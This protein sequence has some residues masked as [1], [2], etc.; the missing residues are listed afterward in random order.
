MAK[1]QEFTEQEGELLIQSLNG[2]T[3]WLNEIGVL[4]ALEGNK[5]LVD[6]PFSTQ[7]WLMQVEGDTVSFNTEVRKKCSF[8]YYK[9]VVL[10]ESFHLMVQKIPNKGD[11]TRIK[12]NFGDQLMKL[13]D[14]EAD[15]YTA[16]YYKEKLNYTLVKFLGLYFDGRTV[17]ND[18]RIRPG[19]FE[20]YIGSLLSVAKLFIEYPKV[21][22]KDIEYDL[23]LPTIAPV[24][25]ESKLHV[26]VIRKKHIYLDEISA[27]HDDFVKLMSCYKDVNDF[28]K[29]AYITKLIN[30]IFKAFN[31]EIPKSIKDEIGKIKK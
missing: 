12:D 11:A 23:Y 27:T 22:S 30:F 31:K 28:T 8:D 4:K 6:F 7:D 14:I 17:F 2:F 15:F 18:E 25:T 19:K 29:Q 13:I 1:K 9:M 3:K 20:R 21:D 16:L 26:L 10:H 24:Y 5:R